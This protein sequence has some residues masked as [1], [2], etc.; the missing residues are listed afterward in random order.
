MRKFSVYIFTLVCCLATAMPVGA[1][2]NLKKLGNAV[3]KTAQAVTLTDAQMAAYVKES[4]DWM[5]KNNPVLPEDN[6][7]TVRLR[8]LTE[9]H[10]M[11]TA[12]GGPL[13]LKVGDILEAIPVHICPAVNLQNQI[14]IVNGEQI[15]EEL[16]IGRGMLQ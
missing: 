4:V 5:D 8:K 13:N 15:R 10:G 1:Q 12:E 14:Y 11:V 6:P 9:E 7:Y 16:V 3:A 2:L